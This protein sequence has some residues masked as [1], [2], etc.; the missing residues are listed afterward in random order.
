MRR[1]LTV[2]LVGRFS[3][4]TFLSLVAFLVACS[5]GEDRSQTSDVPV[6]TPIAI[7]PLPTVSVG[8]VEGDPNQ[9][10]DRVVTPFLLP[11]GQLVVPVAGAR[12]IRV[13]DEHGSFS[14]SLGSEG[15]GP[16]KFQS[17]NAAWARGDTI[18]A[19]D[20]RLNRITRFIPDGTV[21]VVNLRSEVRDL[22]AIAG[23]IPDG[24]IAGGVAVGD[25]GRRDSIVL[26]WFDRTGAD[27]GDVG[28]VEGY[29]R[30]R[31]AFLSGPEPLSPRPLLQVTEGRAYVAESLTPVIRVLTPTGILDREIVWQPETIHTTQDVLSLVIDSAVSQTPEGRAEGLRRHLEAA[32][33]PDRLSVFWKFIVDDHAYIWV[34]SF[35]PLKHA[36]A[37]GGLSLAGGGAGGRWS[38]LAPGGHVV[39]TIDVPADLEVVRITSEAVVGIARDALGVE[40]V[41]VH[42]LERR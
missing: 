14:Y 7:D 23:P 39:G 30:Y 24:W 2:R 10:F 27:R 3:S 16:G 22:S 19:L 28:T 35:E 29:A 4:V 17:L 37:L 31:T 12:S 18:E 5:S 11:D 38:V 20:G 6:G 13:F 41:R 40:S 42:R 8:V 34:R 26:R 21:E 15:A 36:A 32:E 9:E 33:V 25:F 1:R